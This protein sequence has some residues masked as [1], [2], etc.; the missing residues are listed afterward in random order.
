MTEMLSYRAYFLTESDHIRYVMGFKST[1]G[2]SACAQAGAMLARS[3]YAAVELYQDW[4]LVLRSER[5]QQAA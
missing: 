4:R 1:D 5:Q 2:V 3:E